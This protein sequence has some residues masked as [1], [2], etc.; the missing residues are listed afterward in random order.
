MKV[1]LNTLKQLLNFDLPDTQELVTRINEQLGG[2][3]EIIDLGARYK[4][5]V[6]VRVVSAEKHPDADRLSICRVDD[7]G[8]VRDLDRDEQG[9]VQVVC[10]APNVRADMFAIWLP[11]GMTVPSSF[12]TSE[13]FVLSQRDIRGVT[14]NGMLA[15]ADELAIG[16]DHDG[17]VELTVADLPAGVE[18]RYLAP[19]QDFAEL[20]SLDDTIIDIE[21]KMFTHRPD[22]FGQLGVAREL[23]AILQPVPPT[24]EHTDVRFE[25]QSWYWSPAEFAFAEG[26]ELNVFND[27]AYD[28]PRFMAVALQDVVVKPS[29]FWLQTSL[30]RWGSRPINNVVDITNYIMLLTA[31][32]THAYDYDKLRGHSVGARMALPGETLEL[33]NG[34]T[35]TLTDEDM[36]V[37]DAEDAIG[38]AGIMG[39]GNS[40]VSD[41][42]TRIVLEVANFDMYKVRKTAMRHGVFT[43]ALTRFNKGQSPLQNDRV[44]SHLI[45]LMAAHAGTVQA[46]SVFDLP[47]E[48]DDS[49]TSSVH[50]PITV[51]A[52]F[53][54]KRLGL[55][56]TPQHIGNLLRFVNFAVYPAYDAEVLTITAPFWRT[57]IEQAE[58]VVE[59]VG[60]LYGFDKLPRELPSRLMSPAPKNHRRSVV[61]SVR[62]S[63][64]RAGA[65]EVLTYSFVHQHVMTR[66]EQDASKAFRLGNALSPDLQYYRLSMTPSLLDKVHM[67]LKAGHDEFMIF[68]VGKAHHKE[69]FDDEGI[70]REFGRIAAVYA[71]KRSTAGAPYFQAKQTLEVLA[72]DLNITELRYQQL[73]EFDHGEHDAFRQMCAPFDPNRAAI[74]WNGEL[75][76][77]VVGEYKRSVAT[78]YKLPDTVAGF[79]LFVSMFEKAPKQSTYTPLSRYPSISQDISLRGSADTSFGAIDSVVAEVLATSAGD[80]SVTALPTAIYRAEDSDQK[81]TT[82]H[83]VFTSSERTLT[84][85]DI[86]PI[87]TALVARVNDSLG[88]SL[89]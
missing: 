24:D 68:E 53:I 6:I 41:A 87:V 36:V 23:F 4:G 62:D 7:G 8:S 10:G 55:N 59:E 18:E 39:G 42:T 88:L 47:S 5:A 29:P 85:E 48:S 27:A 54:N 89:V 79:E 43:D 81:T 16:T 49:D 70:P 34:K 9:Y 33:L 17:I 56:L 86:A 66:A 51:H 25:E 74:I 2:V 83:L 50:P 63:L 38:L 46:S 45:E 64:S 21:N 19:G 11:P 37:A 3:E 65:N 71:N 78:A 28:A 60:R 13:P 14:S 12:D 22:C 44:M 26:L 67:N 30:V 35:Y 20:F 69:E 57:D 75:L 80:I 58:D 77:G 15:A 61:Q 1:S 72:R 84:D 32:P 73:S 82:Y 31:Q 52:S 40:E 76:C